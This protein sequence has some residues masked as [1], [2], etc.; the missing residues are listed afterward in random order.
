MRNKS[1]NESQIPKY[2]QEYRSSC[3]VRTYNPTR[4]HNLKGLFLERINFRLKINNEIVINNK[5]IIGNW[6]TSK[7]KNLEFFG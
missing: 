7:L 1:R 4:V 5:I 6:L 2:H 3:I